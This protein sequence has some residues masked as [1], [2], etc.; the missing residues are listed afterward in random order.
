MRVYSKVVMM[1]VMME[2]SSAAHWA[3]AMVGEMVADWVRR[4]VAVKAAKTVDWTELQREVSKVG[5]MVV[6]S[7]DPLDDMTVYSKVAWT[8]VK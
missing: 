8:A 4:K 6:T 3:D 1:V 2:E 5:E 7:D